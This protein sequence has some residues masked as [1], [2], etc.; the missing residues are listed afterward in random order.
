MPGICPELSWGQ[1]FTLGRNSFC[2]ATLGWR[3][4]VITIIAVRPITPISP[5]IPLVGVFY[6][7][8]VYR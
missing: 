7:L 8:A 3:K 2:R 4:P 1:K 6:Y 5:L